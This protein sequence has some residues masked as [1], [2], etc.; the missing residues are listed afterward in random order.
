[1]ADCSIC[2]DPI[3]EEFTTTCN[4]TFCNKC[5]MVWIM[6]NDNCPMCRKELTEYDIETPHRLWVSFNDIRDTI[7]ITNYLDKS[8]HCNGF[9]Y[10]H[11]LKYLDDLHENIIKNEDPTFYNWKFLDN[12]YSTIIKKKNRIMYLNVEVCISKNNRNHYYYTIFGEIDDFKNSF[13]KTRT[14]DL[15]FITNYKHQFKNKSNKSFKY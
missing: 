7:F 3:N 4:H 10:T 11:I 14:K 1:M 13:V 5:F 6:S 9:H 2:M 15:N 12:I 8:Y